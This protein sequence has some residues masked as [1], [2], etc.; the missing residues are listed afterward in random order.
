ML[1]KKT[2]AH[3]NKAFR[4]TPSSVK[5]DTVFDTKIYIYKKNLKSLGVNKLIVIVSFIQLEH[6]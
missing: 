4:L 5:T 3:T 1:E 6:N 2:H